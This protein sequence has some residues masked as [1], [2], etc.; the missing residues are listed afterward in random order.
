MWRN[1]L[2]G[3]VVLGM[4]IGFSWMVGTSVASRGYAEEPSGVGTEDVSVKDLGDGLYQVDVKNSSDSREEYA[5]ALQ[6]FYKEHASVSFPPVPPN[7]KGN[8][9]TTTYYWKVNE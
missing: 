8:T 7:P 2:A 6:K 1:V 5:A 9:G 4:A 3:V